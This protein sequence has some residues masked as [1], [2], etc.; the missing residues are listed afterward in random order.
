MVVNKTNSL[1]Q[2]ICYVALHQLAL[3]TA[4]YKQ[5]YIGMQ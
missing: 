4:I 3:E 2:F 5:N 1:E